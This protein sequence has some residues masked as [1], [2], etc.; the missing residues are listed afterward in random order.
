M[1]EP[2]L[3]IVVIYLACGW[4]VHVVHRWNVRNHGAGM[5]GTE[6]V[7]PCR[8]VALVVRDQQHHIEWV[9]RSFM[10]LHWLRGRSVRLTVIDHGSSDC[11][12]KMIR[13]FADRMGFDCVSV[14]T[15]FELYC[16]LERIDDGTLET[17]FLDGSGLER[18]P[19]YL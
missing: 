11:T 18:Q 1:L 5:V 6:A 15:E 4:A 2:L 9:I 3:W 8:N 16:L 10:F 7:I 13:R 14:K 17:I 19:L 12:P